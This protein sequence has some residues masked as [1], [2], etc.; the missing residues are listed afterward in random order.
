[1]MNLKE[2]IKILKDNGRLEVSERLTRSQRAAVDRGF[3]VKRCYQDQPNNVPY[4]F[5]PIRYFLEATDLCKCTA[6]CA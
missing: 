6:T 4:P 5:R 1:M 2:I 3:A